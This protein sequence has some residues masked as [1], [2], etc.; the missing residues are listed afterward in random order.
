M[1]CCLVIRTCVVHL[2]FMRQN[3]ATLAALIH[4]VGSSKDSSITVRNAKSALMEVVCI[5]ERSGVFSMCMLN[6]VQNQ[7]AVRLGA[8]KSPFCINWSHYSTF[9]YIYWNCANFFRD[10]KQHLKKQRLLV[11]CRQQQEDSRRRAGAKERM[12]ERIRRQ[13]RTEISEASD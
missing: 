6:P 5:V 2:Y 8:S 3:A 13:K 9:W 10:L 1:L 12:K 4:I 7:N 11:N